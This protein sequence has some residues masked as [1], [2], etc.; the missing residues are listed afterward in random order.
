MVKRAEEKA[1]IFGISDGEKKLSA[2]IPHTE[3]DEFFIRDGSYFDDENILCKVF[4]CKIERYSCGYDYRIPNTATVYDDYSVN[5]DDD[6]Y[7]WREHIHELPG[8]RKITVSEYRN[9]REVGTGKLL[10]N[11]VYDGPDSKFGIYYRFKFAIGKNRF[12]YDMLGWEWIWGIGVYNFTTDK[13]RDVPDTYEYRPLGCHNGKIYSYYDPYG[14]GTDNIIY[15]TDLNTLETTPLFELDGQDMVYDYEMTSDGRFF[16]NTEYSPKAH[17]F[18][19]ILRSTDTFDVVKEYVFENIFEKPCCTSSTNIGA[20]IISGNE[21]YLY[22]L[23]LD[24]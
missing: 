24:G 18:T 16:V 19:V 3:A 22:I 4:S 8:G 5:P 11:A 10:L 7:G 21:K 13:A 1:K 12:V 20:A 23:G 2:D 14:G 15:V 9:I 6:G 17:T